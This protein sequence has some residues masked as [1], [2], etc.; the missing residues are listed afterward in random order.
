[1]AF[2]CAAVVTWALVACAVVALAVVAWAGPALVVTLL[3]IPVVRLLAPVRVRVTVLLI[4]FLIVVVRLIVRVTTLR[5]G[6]HDW[7]WPDPA[8]ESLM[9]RGR[10]GQTCRSN[11][12]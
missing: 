12:S 1:M 5:L 6:Q 2:V 7:N 9:P 10:R 11:N 3:T 4:V 8:V